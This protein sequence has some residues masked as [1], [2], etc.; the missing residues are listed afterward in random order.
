MHRRFCSNILNVSFLLQQQL[1]IKL[2][3]HCNESWGLVQNVWCHL[4][5]ALDRMSLWC[6]ACWGAFIWKHAIF[7]EALSLFFFFTFITVLLFIKVFVHLKHHHH[8][9]GATLVKCFPLSSFVRITELKDMQARENGVFLSIWTCYK[10][11]EQT[12]VLQAKWDHKNCFCLHTS[13]PFEEDFCPWLSNEL[14]Y[15]VKP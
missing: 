10:H 3:P 11:V 9:R 14:Y 12:G 4:W 13:L 7:S 2:L 15:S 8:L 6:S 1:H 5:L